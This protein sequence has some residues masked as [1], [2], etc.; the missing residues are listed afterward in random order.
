MSPIWENVQDNP[1]ELIRTDRSNVQ[2]SE[3]K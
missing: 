1:S 3:E 2:V